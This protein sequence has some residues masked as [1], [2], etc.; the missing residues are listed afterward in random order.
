MR[1]PGL[2]PQI[3]LADFEGVL[4]GTFGKKFRYFKS[5][6]NTDDRDSLRFAAE[7]RSRD[8]EDI[9]SQDQLETLVPNI[10]RSLADNYLNVEVAL[11]TV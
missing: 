9:Q 11:A 6:I 10:S 8:P 4:T 3:A 1:S 5:T 2:H 7:I